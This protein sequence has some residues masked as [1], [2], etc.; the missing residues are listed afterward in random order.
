VLIISRPA[1]MTT[2]EEGGPPG[3]EMLRDHGLI[4]S[5]TGWPRIRNDGAPGIG[6]RSP[7]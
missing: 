7:A 3:L 6:F 4:F 5:Q 1:Q 2:R